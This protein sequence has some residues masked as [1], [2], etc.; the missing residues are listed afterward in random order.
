MVVREVFMIGNPTLREKSGKIMDFKDQELLI[1]IQDLKDT[2]KHLQ[3]TKR[4]GRALAAPQIGYLR[5]IIYYGLPEEPFVM[6]NP[7]ILWRGKEKFRI[8]DSCFSFNVA[9]FVEIER[10]KSIQVEYQDEVGEK[11][12]KTFSDSLSELI[13]HEIDHLEGILASDHLTDVKKI[14]LR[15]EWE[16]IA[17]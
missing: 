8:W 6:V 12:I 17:H 4:I 11:I 1:I 15:Q 13:Q 14:I 16:K 5:R 7:R 2:L 3:Q 10:Y 9:F